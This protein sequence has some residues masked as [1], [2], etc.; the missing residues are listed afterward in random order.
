MTLIHSEKIESYSGR[1]CCLA[2]GLCLLLPSI[3]I[4]DDI[5]SVQEQIAQLASYMDWL[6]TCMAA[7][8]VFFMQAGFALLESGLI[9]AK[10][11]VEVMMKNVA[12]FSVGVIAFWAIGFGIM[13]SGDLYE[14]FL[15]PD[16]S[17]YGEDP[18]RMYSFLLFQ[19]VCAATVATIA[20]GSMAERT[21]FGAYLAFS[22]LVA[23]V[24]Y[25]VAGSWIKG[26]LWHGGGWLEE[27][28]FV[29]FAGSTVVHSVAG[30]IALAG[31][32]MVGPRLGRFN[33]VGSIIP[34]GR[35]NLG[36]ATLGVFILWLGWFGFNAGST[37]S[38]DG[39][40]FSRVA[41]TTNLAAASGALMALF[42]HWMKFRYPDVGVMLNGALAGLVSV[43]AGCYIMTPLGAL[44]VG[45]IGGVVM[46]F[47]VDFFKRLHIDDPVDAISVHGVCGT[48]GALA[49]TVPFFCRP[50]E[51]A[52]L[53]TQLVGVG[54]IFAY[55]FTV[56]LVMFYAI[57]KTIGLR[58]TESEEIE[59]GGDGGDGFGT[60]EPAVIK[61]ET[62]A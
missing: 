10:N 48:W 55:V 39:G 27:M 37:T 4:A 43:A 50:N 6:W 7:F 5:S 14:F 1:L 57:K 41:V 18:N 34:M 2:M 38:I 29:D 59:G 28:G 11:A 22:I 58:L 19:T 33:R 53:M 36:M 15:N 24:I 16:M 45:A 13:F 49:C 46:F 30:W 8:I 20:S 47:S 42:A 21:R 44:L 9:R 23:A 52:E 40:S 60:I 3:A 26:G 17:S 31:A 25:P 54:S 35:H 32:I 62:P 56:S 12:I 61:G 51:A